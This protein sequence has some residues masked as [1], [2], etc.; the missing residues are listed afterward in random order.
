MNFVPIPNLRTHPKVH[1][2]PESFG[3]VP[4]SLEHIIPVDTRHHV[5]L[6]VE[7]TPELLGLVNN[8]E[9]FQWLEIVIKFSQDARLVASHQ[10]AGGIAIISCLHL[11][12]L[13]Y[14]GQVPKDDSG[15]GR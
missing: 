14:C 2:F 6:E 10:W 1:E 8:W 15:L 7:H 3:P 4:V 9:C 5:P 12:I 13:H 11:L